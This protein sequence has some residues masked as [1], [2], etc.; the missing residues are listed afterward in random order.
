M[1]VKG[2]TE[3]GEE[4]IMGEKALKR[5]DVEP[6]IERL[7]EVTEFVEGTFIECSVSDKVIVSMNIALDEIFSNITYYSGAKYVVA[8]CGVI[9]GMAV[10]RLYDDGKPYDPTKAAEVDITETAEER[11]IG[12]LGIH[13][14]KNMMDELEYAY[15]DGMNILTMKKR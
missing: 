6:G 3:Y 13:M 12:G 15:E 2:I 1:S 4:W 11:K 9:D 10:L 14:V 7:E 8:E 5:I